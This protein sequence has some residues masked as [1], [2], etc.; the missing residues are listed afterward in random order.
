MTHN[1]N[2]G[3]D[4]LTG[5]PYSGGGWFV[6]DNPDNW[7]PSG[8]P[9]S[10]LYEFSAAPNPGAAAAYCYW[11]CARLD[12]RQKDGKRRQMDMVK[13]DLPPDQI[14]PGTFCQDTATG[15]LYFRHAIGRLGVMP[16][17]QAPQR[18]AAA[19]YWILRWAERLRAQGEVFRQA[20]HG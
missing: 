15:K 14:P 13:L 16:H 12:Y 20:G 7:K 9:A 18:S 8:D 3:P 2:V 11:Y 6:L 4:S 10:G 5:A 1:F 19:V 17:R